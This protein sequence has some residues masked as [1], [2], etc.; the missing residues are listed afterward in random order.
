MSAFQSRPFDPFQRGRVP[1]GDDIPALAR[2]WA[3]VTRQMDGHSFALADEWEEEARRDRLFAETME[4]EALVQAITEPTVA[5]IAL[6]LRILAWQM[7]IEKAEYANR[8]G[9]R[10]NDLDVDEEAVASALADAMRLLNE[11][12]Y[13]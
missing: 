2:R 9:V 8:D 7:N 5:G 4:I 3:E 6:K 11:K 1:A 13:S 10:T 12:M